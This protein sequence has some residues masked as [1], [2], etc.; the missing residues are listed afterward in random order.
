MKFYL[1]CPWYISGGPE[2]L[3]QCCSELNNA[4][5][6]SYIVYDNESLS[7][8]PEYQKYNVKSLS[9]NH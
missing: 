1:F 6:D 5:Y 4:G 2:A 9:I 3:H 8:I 7:V